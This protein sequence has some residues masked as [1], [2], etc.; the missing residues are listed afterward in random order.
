[1]EV[2]GKVALAMA[3]NY[4]VHYVSMTAHNW[5]CIPHTLGEVAKTLFT[6]ASPACSTLLVV[7]QHTQNAYAAA[8]TTGVTALIIDVLKSSA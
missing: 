8:V 2:L 7:G 6:T 5:M 3:L 4:G 1:M